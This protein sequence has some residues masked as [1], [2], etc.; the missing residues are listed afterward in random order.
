[1][2]ELQTPSVR[3][4]AIPM[5]RSP[6]RAIATCWGLLE[7]SSQR[8]GD[9]ARCPSCPRRGGLSSA[10]SRSRPANRRSSRSR[11]SRN[12][13][14]RERS[15]HAAPMSAPSDSIRA[16]MSSTADPL[17]A[18]PALPS[19]ERSTRSWIPAASRAPRSSK[20]RCDVLLELALGRRARGSGRCRLPLPPCRLDPKTVDRDLE[21]TLGLVDSPEVPLPEREHG[22]ALRADPI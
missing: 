11:A 2:N 9:S 10:P 17:V 22:D 12:A 7:R 3:S 20:R 8:L 6:S 13:P 15:L 1:M 4:R 16:A 18:S 5:M 21:D 19:S 14:L